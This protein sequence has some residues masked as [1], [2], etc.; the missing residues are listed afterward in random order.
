MYIVYKEP[1]KI[2]HKIYPVTITLKFIKDL[3][4]LA[5]LKCVYRPS[6]EANLS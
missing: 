6:G 4:T 5:Y 3:R 2:A 1:Q